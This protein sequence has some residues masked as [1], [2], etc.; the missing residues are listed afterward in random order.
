[1]PHEPPLSY[2]RNKSRCWS[3]LC[4]AAA[5]RRRSRPRSRPRCHYVM[6]QCHYVMV[7]EQR[8]FRSWSC[9]GA[10]QPPLHRRRRPCSRAGLPGWLGNR[11]CSHV[12]RCSPNDCSRHYDPIWCMTAGAA[13]AAEA[14]LKH[15]F[16]QN[17]L[18]NLTGHP[19]EVVRLPLEHLGFHSGLT[20]RDCIPI[21]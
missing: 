20:S 21:A 2:P 19:L 11:H 15:G 10:R 3:S 16:R 4:A 9:P 7:R 8:R 1:M 18:W 6:V 5:T 12:Y 17:P 14:A 13:E